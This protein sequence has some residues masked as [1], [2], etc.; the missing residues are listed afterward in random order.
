MRYNS[1]PTSRTDAVL[2]GFAQHAQDHVKGKRPAKAVALSSA[3]LK[4]SGPPPAL[5]PRPGAVPG[6][7][8]ASGG[9]A[10]T[11]AGV[12]S[13]GL[14]PTSIHGGF[15]SNGSNGSGGFGSNGGGVGGGVGGGGGF[16]SP[17]SPRSPKGGMKSGPAYPGV[18]G[19]GVAQGAAEGKAAVDLAHCFEL[20]SGK[21]LG[22]KR[23]REG[24][25]YFKV[26]CL[27]WSWSGRGWGGER[28]GGGGSSIFV[29]LVF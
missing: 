11:A 27:S 16:M 7:G 23:N 21:L 5:P 26:C 18:R 9:A 8:G 29:C 17:R 14:G 22:D 1:T 15:G 12:G 2:L 25:L 24:R 28:G 6:A 4:K 20:H 19:P 3:L 10:T 13:L